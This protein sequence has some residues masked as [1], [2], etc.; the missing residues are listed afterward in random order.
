[1]I[2]VWW[3]FLIC[4]SILFRKVN[5]FTLLPTIHFQIFEKFSRFWCSTISVSSYDVFDSWIFSMSVRFF[6]ICYKFVPKNIYCLVCFAISFWKFIQSLCS[7]NHFTRSNFVLCKSI[8]VLRNERKKTFFEHNK[9]SMKFS[10]H[11]I[12]C[13]HTSTHTQSKSWYFWWTCF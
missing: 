12:N 1:M 8:F 10:C 13:F 7:G 3:W 2:F 9:M 11:G 6:C 5:N 4:S